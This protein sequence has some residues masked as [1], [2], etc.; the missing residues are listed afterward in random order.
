[1]ITIYLTPMNRVLLEEVRVTQVVNKAPSFMEPRISL[2][3]SQ[4]PATLPVNFPSSKIN[5]Y[6][7]GIRPSA[8]LL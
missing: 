5:L 3:R 8:L 7:S 2:Q 6:A 4:D 1:V